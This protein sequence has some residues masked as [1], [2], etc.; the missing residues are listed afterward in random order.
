MTKLEELK[1][2]VDAAEDDCKAAYAAVDVATYDADNAEDSWF[3]TDY[4]NYAWN[5]WNAAKDA[6]DAA[7]DTAYNAVYAHA[8]AN[9]AYVK[10][11]ERCQNLKN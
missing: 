3:A 11:L 9:A 7:K 2:A 6:V 1:A 4:A 10:E 8:A 5:T